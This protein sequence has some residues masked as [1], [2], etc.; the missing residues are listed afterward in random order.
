MKKGSAK[1]KI[2]ASQQIETKEKDFSLPKI[3]ISKNQ[4]YV[5]LTIL[6]LIALIYL[7]ILYAQSAR[8]VVYNGLEFEKTKQGQI[9]LYRASIPATDYATG[10]KGYLTVD[11]RNNPKTLDNIPVN[12]QAYLFKTSN[13]TYV[14]YENRNNTYEDGTLAGANLGRFLN[15]IGLTIKSAMSDKS[16]KNNTYLPYV[17]C[18]TNPNNTVI[19]LYESSKNRIDQVKENCYILSFRGEDILKV[20]E[21]FQLAILEKIMMGT[22]KA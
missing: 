21:K 16:F 7:A 10:A 17:T 22:G 8:I 2:N 3:N 15:T 6:G 5:G 4:I 20:T 19:M 18:D 11:F 9:L 12:I 1:K 14:S 13:T